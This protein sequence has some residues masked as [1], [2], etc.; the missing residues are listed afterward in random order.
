[1]RQQL[2][3]LEDPFRE[4]PTAHSS[5]DVIAEHMVGF[6]VTDQDQSHLAECSFLVCCLSTRRQDD[7]LPVH[8]FFDRVG[9]SLSS[10]PQ[11]IVS[12]SYALNKHQTHALLEQAC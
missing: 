10:P 11:R 12:R 7:E 1:M 8:F 5:H 3:L 9:R 4:P 2:C 6:P